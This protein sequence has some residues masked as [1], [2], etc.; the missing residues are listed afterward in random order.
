MDNKVHTSTESERIN[1][2][3]FNFFMGSLVVAFIAIIIL[4]FTSL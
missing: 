2:W 1:E 4:G 3:A